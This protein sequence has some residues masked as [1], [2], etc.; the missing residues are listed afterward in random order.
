MIRLISSWETGL[1]LMGINS[2]LREQVII[3]WSCLSYLASFYAS[4]ST[5]TSLLCSDT[6]QQPHHNLRRCWHHAFRL[7]CHQNH[8][9]NRPILCI[10]DLPTE[11]K[12]CKVIIKQAKTVNNLWCPF[13]KILFINKK[14]WAMKPYK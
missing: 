1:V 4:A 3:K 8:E 2:F 7:C 10:S 9:P 6:V 5:F 12:E 13:N 14:K 11:Y